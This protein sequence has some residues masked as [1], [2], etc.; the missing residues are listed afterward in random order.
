MTLI[1]LR[2]CENGTQTL[3]ESLTFLN[4]SCD[5][6]KRQNLNTRGKSEVRM[7]YLIMTDVKIIFPVLVAAHLR[8]AS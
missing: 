6:A 4:S 5:F 7:S 2:L 3:V 8:N 1:G